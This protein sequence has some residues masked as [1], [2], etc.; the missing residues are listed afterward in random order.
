MERNKNRPAEKK[1]LREKTGKK[2]RTMRAEI[3]KLWEEEIEEKGFNKLNRL[4]QGLL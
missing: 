4:K 2:R 3:Y 1:L